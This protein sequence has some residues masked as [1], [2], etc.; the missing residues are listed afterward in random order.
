[1]LTQR[2]ADSVRGP[3]GLG[4]SDRTVASQFFPV[5][6]ITRG[7]AIAGKAKTNPIAAKVDNFNIIGF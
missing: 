5:Q 4:S 3:E 2:R 7:D 6:S 1:M